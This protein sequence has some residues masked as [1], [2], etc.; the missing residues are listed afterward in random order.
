MLHTDRGPFLLGAWYRPPGSE[1]TTISSCGDE[2]DKLVEGAMGTIL[3]GDMNVHHKAWW[4]HFSSTTAEGEAL[5][6]V[7]ADMGLRAGG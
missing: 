3:V 6:A 5:R 7:T 1:T 4:M 2:Y